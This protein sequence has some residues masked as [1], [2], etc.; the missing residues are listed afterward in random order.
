[1][2]YVSSIVAQEQVASDTT[3]SRVE[4]IQSENFIKY[5]KD[6]AELDSLR[7][8]VI[9]KHDST[10][11]YCDTAIIVDRV[12]ITA[13]GDV[14]IVT[15]D[16]LSMFCDSLVYRSDTKKANMFGRVLL[17]NGHE[18]LKT[19][20]L[21]YDLQSE[22]AIFNSET[23]LTKGNTIVRSRKGKYISN[24]KQA[25]FYQ[26]VEVIDSSF[27]LKTD[28][29]V[30]NREK[31]QADFTGPTRINRK[32]AKIYCTN[33]FYNLKDDFAKFDDNAQYVQ[34]STI[35][36]AN[37][38]FFDG[39]KSEVL[40][41]G[42]GNLKVAETIA[43]ANQIVYNEVTEMTYLTGNGYINDGNKEL[44]SDY[45]EYDKKSESI[46]TEG[47]AEIVDSTSYLRAD[48]LAY[49]EGGESIAQGNVEYI[50]HESKL[51]VLSDILIQ[52]D[53]ARAS[54]LV[55]QE[56]NP[57][58]TFQIDTSFLYLSAD[59][60]DIVEDS[61]QN[62]VLHAY[63]NVKILGD[64]IQAV[65]DS[66]KYNSVDS[67]FILYRNPFVF[68][69]TSQFSGDTIFLVMRENRI[70]RVDIHQNAMIISESQTEVFDQIKGRMVHSY[71]I[72]GDLEN[73]EVRGSAQS[74]YYV[75]D[76]EDAYIGV[77]KSECSDMDILF[78][79]GDLDEMIFL[80]DPTSELTPIEQVVHSTF[81]L[82]GFNW[83]IAIRPE[84]ADLIRI[85]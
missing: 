71:F 40:L 47:Q 57:L 33:G 29:L 61:L 63:R 51:S 22:T 69:N 14:S 82:P 65:C 3:V 21:D 17:E 78:V 36:T 75:A 74:I 25:Y 30:Y 84:D 50:D 24:Q 26:D 52:D 64:D 45:I 9:I 34:D 62:K 35:A 53:S 83:N 32:N 77:N 44:T 27:I 54:R 66:L 6:G 42:N 23:T 2:L 43:S 46:V 15:G 39:N 73:M 28:T 37:T 1:M 59:T 56:L 8:D 16:T 55:G 70:D 31:E 38:I 85:Q 68:T 76:E 11:M 60:I 79:D 72:D 19:N 10:Y 58:L 48:G 18:S 41:E 7:G 81:R 5:V 49:G 20:Q 67:T 4:I 13:F 80:D 12:H